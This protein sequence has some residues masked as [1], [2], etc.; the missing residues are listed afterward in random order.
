[1]GGILDNLTNAINTWNEKLAE[2]WL[3]LT[4]SPQNFK[5]GGIWQAITTIHNALIAIG[6]A[7]LVLFLYLAWLKPVQVFRT[8]KDQNRLRNYSFVLP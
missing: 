3:L 1:M 7:L 8:S 4:Q 5:G 6:L 2:I